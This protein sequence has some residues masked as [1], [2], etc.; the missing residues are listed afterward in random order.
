MR[1]GMAWTLVER[2]CSLA[3]ARESP[4]SKPSSS[5]SNKGGRGCITAVMAI[6]SL[7]VIPVEWMTQATGMKLMKEEEEG[8]GYWVD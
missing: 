2:K 8:G 5:F 7:E 6:S 3:G 1:L 4:V